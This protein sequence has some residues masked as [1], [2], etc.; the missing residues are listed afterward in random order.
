M[1]IATS[2][3]KRGSK[4]SVSEPTKHHY[5]MYTSAIAGVTQ[6]FIH[7]FYKEIC[8]ENKQLGTFDFCTI[9]AEEPTMVC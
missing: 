6:I 2:K 9:S 3:G 4:T 7:E 1:C 5:C 8:R